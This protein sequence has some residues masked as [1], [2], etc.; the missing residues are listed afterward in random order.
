MRTVELSEA[1]QKLPELVD[2]AGKGERIG[3]TR[4]GELIA[5]IVPAHS[6]HLRE[7]F[8]SIEQIRKRA[9]PNKRGR[10]KELIEQGR[11]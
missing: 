10:A 5:L 2:R 8:D 3:I 9:K 7:I 4:S 11:V 6:L 1:K